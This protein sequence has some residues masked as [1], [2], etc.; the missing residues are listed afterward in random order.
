[1]SD[2]HPLDEYFKEGLNEHKMQPSQSVWDKI[3]AAAPAPE[4]SRKGGWY[5]M[6]AA[7][8]VLLIGLSSV[9]YYQN[10][11]VD[12]NWAAAPD[13]TETKGPEKEKKKTEDQ[14]KGESGTSVEK[15]SESNEGGQEAKPKKKPVPIMRQ[16]TGRQIY[17]SNEDAL[18]PIDESSLMDES[19]PMLAAVDLKVEE[20]TKPAPVKIKFKV[21][22]K[23]TTQGFY[24]NEE[25]SEPAESKKDFKD[26]LYAYA[27]NQFDNIKNGK[28]VELPKPEKKP[29]IEIDLGKIF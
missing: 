8:V 9:F 18:S 10:H 6:R 13:H 24:P 3:E 20:A 7:V 1:M 22:P 12:E 16:S 11:G 5:I 23:V 28:P 29:Q 27:S 26:R 17:V 25:S 21:K 19:K 15:K 4:K 2:K 14:Q